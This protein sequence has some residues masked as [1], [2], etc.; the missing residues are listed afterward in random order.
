M[1]S[2]RPALIASILLILKIE[3]DPRL[4]VITMVRLG[5]WMDTVFQQWLKDNPAQL[6][7]G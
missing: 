4:E 7:K 6:G 3:G 1:L 5:E 2:E